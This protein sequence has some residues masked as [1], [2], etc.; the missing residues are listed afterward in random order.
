MKINQEKVSIRR[1]VIWL[2]FCVS[3]EIAKE[4]FSLDPQPAVQ[5]HKFG[6][7]FAE[8]LKC[9]FQNVTLASSFPIQSYPIVRRLMF[10]GGPFLTKGMSG[11]L[12]GFFNVI[13]IKHATRLISCLIAV[14]PIIKRN[15]IDWIFIHGLH[16]PYLIFGVL[17][18]LLGCRIVVVLTDPPGMLL[19]TDG[20]TSRLLK[21]LDVWLLKRMLDHADGVVALAADLA[22]KMAP[23]LPALIFP[24]ILEE[25]LKDFNGEVDKQFGENGELKPFTIVYAGGLNQAYGVDRLIE[26]VFSFDSTVPV[27]LRLF[28]RGDQ[29][30][31]IRSL[32][33]SDCRFFYGGFVDTLSLFPEL[34][35]ADLLINPRP[36]NELFSSLSF[37]SKLIEYL[38][39]GQSVLTTRIASIPPSL[40]EQYYYI[41][42]ESGDGIRSAIYEVMRLPSHQRLAHAK[43]ARNLVRSEF[44]V[45]SIGL[46]ISEFVDGLEKDNN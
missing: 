44:S 3:E 20:P 23:A 8:A 32:V 38:A 17:A 25:S 2:G 42:D 18:R 21:N 15:R 39:V 4:L 29:E 24:G 30:N 26:A 16:S 10:R 6:W 28:G 41:D 27:R 35:N 22:E 11:V 33:K 5:T 19:E 14:L 37:P 12:L 34:K 40:A 36:T 9:A 31:R 45:K 1:N 46:R 7:S 43:S 13:L